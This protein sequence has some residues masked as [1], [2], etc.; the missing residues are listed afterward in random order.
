MK[1]KAYEK[2][3][4]LL[5]DAIDCFINSVVT[6]PNNKSITKSNIK[7]DVDSDEEQKSPTK[8]EIVTSSRKRQ[9]YK[10]ITSKNPQFYLTVGDNKTT[11]SRFID[12]IDGI[13][14]TF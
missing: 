1:E 13:F 5:N 8:E 4:S 7:E 9:I 10:K 11:I 2:K 14:Q 6:S 12:I 3:I